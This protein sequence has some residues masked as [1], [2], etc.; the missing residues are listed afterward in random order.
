MTK[1]E[2]LNDMMI[3]I[4][5]KNQFNL[6]DLMDRYDISK[7]TAL[8]DIVSLEAIGMP[9]YAQHGR[10][11]YY[12]LLKN[13]LLAPI[14]FTLDD[15]QALY[16]AMLTLKEY[17]TTPFHLEMATLQAKFEGCLSPHQL[18]TLKDMAVV[19][20]LSGRPHPNA[21]PFLKTILEKA[22]A[23]EVVEMT[24]AK[25][26]AIK[27]YTVQFLRI[28]VDF[29]QWYVTAYHVEANAIKVFRCDKVTGV[30]AVYKTEKDSREALYEKHKM[31]LENSEGVP[32]EVQ[33]HKDGA[34]VF[35]KEH[36]PG[37][38][39]E[40]SDNG[41]VIKGRYRPTETPFIVNYLLKFGKKVTKVSPVSLLTALKEALEEQRRHF[42]T[43]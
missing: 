30:R 34:D 1:S 38:T 8:R 39:L 42:K 25:G 14:V 37:M 11:G 20:K 22:I 21:C 4:N 3:Y 29:S 18:K 13:R 31:W 15:V 32:Y 10:L 2:R 24:Y 43:L 9:L 23:N 35:Y 26:D 40:K 6:K 19:L 7:S 27:P 33:V 16:F 36:Y 12:G 17:Q 5:A 28:T 41:Y